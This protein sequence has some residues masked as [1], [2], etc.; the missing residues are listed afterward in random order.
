VD[1]QEMVD[2]RRPARRG[3]GAR[4]RRIGRGSGCGGGRGEGWKGRRRSEREEEEE[5][6]RRSKRTEAC[7]AATPGIAGEGSEIFG[8]RVLGFV[9]FEFGL[10]LGSNAHFSSSCF[11]VFFLASNCVH[12]WF[13]HFAFNHLSTSIS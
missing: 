8:P 10:G 2:K 9:R 5:E 12:W 13:Y 11:N 3:R 4:V 6:R 7:M 1:A